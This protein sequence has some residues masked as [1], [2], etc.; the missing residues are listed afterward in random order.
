MSL[1][2]I[3]DL[4]KASVLAA[5]WNHARVW[6]T[7]DVRPAMSESRALAL[8]QDQKQLNFDWVDSRVLKVDLTADWV[9]PWLYDRDNGGDGAAYRVIQRLR[10]NL[11]LETSDEKI[12]EVDARKASQVLGHGE[13]QTQEAPLSAGGGDA[14]AHDASKVTK[15]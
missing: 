10:A 5:L 15:P 7:F 12:P 11:H 2:D 8:V 9:D 1:I 4:P 13:G 3:R 6:S 14:G